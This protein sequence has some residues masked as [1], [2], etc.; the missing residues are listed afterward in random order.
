MH[1]KYTREKTGVLQEGKVSKEE[2]GLGDL[3]NKITRQATHI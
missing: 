3:H 1:T 2:R